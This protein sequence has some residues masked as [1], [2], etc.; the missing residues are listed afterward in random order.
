MDAVK[1]NPAAQGIVGKKLEAAHKRG[2]LN[3]AIAML[4]LQSVIDREVDVLSGGEL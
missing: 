1:K 3:E 4:D 2:N